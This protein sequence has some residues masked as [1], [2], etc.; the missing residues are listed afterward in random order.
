MKNQILSM[1]LFFTVFLTGCAFLNGLFPSEHY[2]NGEAIEGT[3]VLRNEIG[4]AVNTIPAPY[5][6]AILV[7]AG[8]I[9]GGWNLL[10]KYKK[11]KAALAGA[12]T[13]LI[14]T[15]MTI[16]HAGEDPELAAAIAKIKVLLAR[17]HQAAGVQN[18]VNDVLA[19]LPPTPTAP[20]Q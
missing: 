15:I 17:S 19:K 1:V 12:N 16:E 2:T 20:S 7:L 8:I 11:T 18:L 6:E 4:T 10:E 13:G 3:H 14:S 5:S 9:A